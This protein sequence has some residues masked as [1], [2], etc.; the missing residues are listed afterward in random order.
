MTVTDSSAQAPIT[1]AEV[2]R[3]ALRRHQAAF[4]Q[5]AQRSQHDRHAGLIVQV[6]RFDAARVRDDR[7]RVPGDQVADLDA[8]G[9]RFGRGSGPVVQPDLHL[10]RLPFFVAHRFTMNMHRGL[11]QQRRAGV[12]AA[13]RGPDP[14]VL[15]VDREQRVTADAAEGQPA[16]G[17]D[18]R[19]DGAQRV[20]VS[21]DGARRGVGAPWQGHSHRALPGE[22]RRLAYL[23]QPAHNERQRVF[24]V[25]G[26]AGR[27][28]ELNE[29]RNKRV[30]VDGR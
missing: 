5:R 17:F 3:R 14:A 21:R 4:R 24:G 18:L 10:V 23:A 27:A 16:I 25:T 26:G 30:E 15:A 20:H 28:E 29:T 22:P 1:V 7:A 12:G 11:H 13:V 6:P 2:E 8:Q 9:A 19:H